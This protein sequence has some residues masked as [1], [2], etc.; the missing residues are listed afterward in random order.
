MKTTMTDVRFVCGMVSVSK[1]E[2]PA[3]AE[4]DNVRIGNVLIPVAEYQKLLD[5]K[6]RRLDS[7][8]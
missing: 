7:H 3:A 5:Y 1:D 6:L 2:Y 8:E 4:K